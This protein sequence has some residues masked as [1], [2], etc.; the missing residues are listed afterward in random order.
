MRYCGYGRSRRG[1]V[2]AALYRPGAALPEAYGANG[3]PYE[4]WNLSWVVAA[5]LI[6]ELGSGQ[7]RSSRP[8]APAAAFLAVWQDTQETRT[9]DVN[10]RGKKY[11]SAADLCEVTVLGRRG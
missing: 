3:V 6:M 11:S 7:G 10:N 1:G 5:Q 4:S 9:G 8:G 2:H